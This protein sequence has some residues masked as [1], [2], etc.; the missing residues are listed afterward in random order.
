[1]DWS[2][3]VVVVGGALILAGVI[4]WIYHS[5]TSKM[6]APILSTMEGKIPQFSENLGVTTL[7]GVWQGEKVKIEV[8][9]TRTGMPNWV[10]ITL[11]R[12][13]PFDTLRILPR[14][15]GGFV[16]LSAPQEG[17]LPWPTFGVKISDEELESNATF[18]APEEEKIR[19]FLNAARRSVVR[20]L[21]KKKFNC[22]EI[23]PESIK[24]GMT[25]Y[26]GGLGAYKICRNI[27][28]PE[29]ASEVLVELLDFSN[30]V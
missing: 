12:P 5:I 26:W 25:T 14:D 9:V 1:M 18:I 24:V 17:F 20:D 6:L 16:V 13:F 29:S 28:K 8:G 21:F 22:I 23:A 7:E 10:F 30:E 4:V 19:K 2:I 27:V 15:E 11:S 3:L